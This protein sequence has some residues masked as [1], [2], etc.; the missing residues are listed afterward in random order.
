MSDSGRNKKIDLIRGIAIIFMV[1]G[2]ARAPGSH[3]IA[4][5]NLNYS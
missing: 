2:H 1:M 5:F 4:L 3:F